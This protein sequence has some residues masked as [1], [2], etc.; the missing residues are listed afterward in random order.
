VEEGEMRRVIITGG[1]GFLGSHLVQ[2]F[3][4]MGH[5]IFVPKREHFDL[6]YAHAAAALFAAFPKPDVVVHCAATVG[7]IGANQRLPAQFL[8]DNVLLNTNIV[9][10]ARKY[11]TRKFVG[12]GSVCGYP[13][14]PPRIPFREEDYLGDYPEPT[15]APYGYTKRLLLMQLRAE[16]EQYGL[17]YTYVIPTNLYGP[18]D[19]FDPGSS[20]VIPALLKKFHQGGPTAP[21][22]VWGTGK[23]TR[24][25]L[26]V[27]DACEAIY[28]ASDPSFECYLPINLGSG[29]ETSIADL[30]DL[31]AE[32][33][34]YE[35]E[36][37]WDESKPDGQPRRVLDTS[38][39][40]EML[41]WRPKVS[42]ETGIDATYRHWM[43]GQ[44]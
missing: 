23:A 34:H 37:F 8:A 4:N 9:I 16:A 41:N 17:R 35:G 30:V 32:L 22:R 6:R 15:N 14:T 29:E 3:R 25:F 18:G 28:R 38:Y 44:E 2:Y 20:H 36:T 11:G 33:T 12:I 13:H 21:V 24:D 19:N 10:Q 31:I 1:E 40:D 26:Y 43:E 5:A 42:L 7:G 39:A 27:V